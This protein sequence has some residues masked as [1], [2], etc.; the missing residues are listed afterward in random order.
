MNWDS[1][2]IGRHLKL[3][4]LNVLMAVVR[5]GSM[6]KAAAQLALSQPAVSKTIAEMEQNLG[7]RLLD[8]SP[9]GVEP[10]IYARALLDHGIIAFD[11]L[12]QAIGKIESLADPSQG[13]LRIGCT[14]V[15]AQGF[16]ANV[17]TRMAQRY[18]RVTFELMAEESGSVYRALEDRKL[19]L[20]IARIFNAVPGHLTAEVLYDDRHVV[21]AGARNSWSRR[22]RVQLA[23]LMNEP[24]V[25]PPLET[26][27]GSIV[28]EAFSVR[29]LEVPVATITTSSTPARLAL[30]AGGQFISIL[31]ITTLSLSSKKP[32]PRALSIDLSTGRRPIAVVMLK[33]RGP[34]PVAQRFIDN[35]RSAAKSFA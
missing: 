13:H 15:L 7:V 3:R 27:T 16:V 19:D 2:R 25:L 23:D 5:W 4:D 14:V 30:V 32:A 21:A 11:E 18:P 22:R 12:A 34:S 1:R 20:A 26:L 28:R 29:K 6:G 10:T 24:W 35:A 33:D 8:R 31:P 17:I 9:H